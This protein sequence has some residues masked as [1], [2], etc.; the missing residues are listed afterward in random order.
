MP[1]QPFMPGTDELKVPWLNHFVDRLLDTGKGYATKYGVSSAMVTKLDDG[2]KLVN[3]IWQVLDDI[4]TGSQ[5][6]T[7]FK[8][9]V[10]EGLDP[11]A[12]VPVA[13]AF[14]PVPS[15]THYAGVFT[16]AGAVGAGIKANPIYAVADGE[17]M[18]LEGAVIVNPSIPGA[19]ELTMRKSTAG[20][21]E[22][23]WKKKGHQGIKV[24]W[25]IAGTADWQDAGLDL[26]PPFNDPRPLA[27]AG[28]PEVRE[29]RA[30]YIDDEVPSNVWST[31]LSVTVTP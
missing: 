2:R 16:L 1:K 29:Y 22:I 8:Q 11:L 5:N 13:P 19:P 9:Q 14:D 26:N 15:G 7:R 3:W 18:G 31:I 17:D 10:F 6:C 25:R 28:V 20:D 21:V 27:H 30:C 4:R 12:E 24:Q 23:G